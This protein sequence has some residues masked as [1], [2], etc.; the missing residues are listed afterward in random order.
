MPASYGGDLP[1]GDL[2]PAEVVTRTLLAHARGKQPGRY[3]YEGEFLSHAVELD[4]A[5]PHRGLDATTEQGKSAYYSA[6]IDGYAGEFDLATAIAA[7]EEQQVSVAT[8]G[9]A[10]VARVEDLRRS[11]WL[12]RGP[13]R[14]CDEPLRTLLAKDTSDTRLDKLRVAA[15]ETYNVRGIV[16]EVGVFTGGVTRLFGLMLPH[17]RVIG[18]DTFAGLPPVMRHTLDFHIPGDFAANYGEVSEYLEDLPNVELRA[19]FFPDTGRN[20]SEERFSLVHIDT[21]LYETTRAALEFFWPRMDVEGQIVLDDY[22]W[23]DTKGVT[24]AVDGFMRETP[25]AELTKLGPS[26]AR[27][28]DLRN[29]TTSP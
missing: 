19:G 15:L 20:L 7:L 22:G 29:S 24:Q 10:T 6:R 1:Q 21:D 28:T 5:A 23:R 11:G 4:R 27:V 14:P 9:G 2:P 13:V 3:W 12:L 26:Q 17:K 25:G 18:F 16:A 8:Y